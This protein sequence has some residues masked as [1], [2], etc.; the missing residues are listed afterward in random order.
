VIKK[1]DGT[2]VVKKIKVVVEEDDED[3][4]HG[5]DQMPEPPQKELPKAERKKK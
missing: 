4:E 5:I 2:K 1:D 3:H